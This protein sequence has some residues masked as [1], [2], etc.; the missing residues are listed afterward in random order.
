[1][2]KISA[3]I[4]ILTLFCFVFS[5]HDAHAWWI[6]GGKDKKTQEIKKTP[7]ESETSL[8]QPLSAAF[9]QPPTR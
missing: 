4:T 2:K 8:G 6:F 5:G 1:M 7:S 3:L 9:E